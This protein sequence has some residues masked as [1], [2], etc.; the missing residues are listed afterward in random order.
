MRLLSLRR[1]VVLGAAIILLA[2]AAVTFFVGSRDNNLV[3]DYVGNGVYRVKSN[4]QMQHENIRIGVGNF[5]RRDYVDDAGKTVSG[6]TCGLWIS[7]R[8]RPDL[9]ETVSVHVGQII[10]VEN[11]NITRIGYVN[12]AGVVELKVTP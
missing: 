11:Y 3:V 7:V 1:K 8:D 4:T 5:N 6:E 9:A 12:S 2:V 10:A